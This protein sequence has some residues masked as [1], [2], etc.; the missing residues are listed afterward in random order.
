MRLIVYKVKFFS[1]L[2]ISFSSFVKED[3]LSSLYDT[4]IQ[5]SIMTLLDILSFF[6]IFSFSLFFIE[7]VIYLFEDDL[8]F[9]ELLESIFP[10]FQQSGGNHNFFIIVDFKYNFVTIKWISAMVKELL[11]ATIFLTYQFNNTYNIGEALRR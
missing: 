9:F 7:Q 10:S 5:C 6:T 3:R 8:G 2:I 4:K 1:P 11:S